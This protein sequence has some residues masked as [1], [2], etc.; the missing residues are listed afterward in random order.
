[1]NERDQEE[2][3]ESRLRLNPHLT[4]L[5]DVHGWRA[6]ENASRV[7]LGYPASFVTTST[8]AF[9]IASHLSPSN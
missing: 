7:W 5:V 6:V 1:M 3:H 2:L 8:E 4:G 9:A